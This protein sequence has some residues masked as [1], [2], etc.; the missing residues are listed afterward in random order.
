MLR[1]CTHVAD[2]ENQAPPEQAAAR[3]GV[4]RRG[5]STGAVV[6]LVVGVAV[7]AAVAY[8][9]PELTGILNLKPWDRAEP[10]AMVDRFFEAA[11]ASDRATT[12]QLCPGVEV[13]MAEGAIAGL[14]S[15]NSSPQMR[16][17]PIER[18][19]PLE[20]AA[21]VTPSY[22]FRRRSVKMVIPTGEGEAL[23]LVLKRPKTEWVIVGFRVDPR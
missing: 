15:P 10:A 17:T 20:S 4:R 16:P 22:D 21:S 18:L 12:E 3:P 9:H 19:L 1:G 6:T 14:K 13:E 8:F 7:V 11:R 5:V 2:T 23:T